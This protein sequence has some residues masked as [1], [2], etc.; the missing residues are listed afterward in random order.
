M[1]LNA[2]SGDIMI[3]ADKLKLLTS[4]PAS[5]LQQSVGIKDVTF[6]GAQFLGITNGGEFCYSVVYRAPS[7]EGTDSTK[8]FLKYDPTEDMVS[9]TSELTRW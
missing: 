2:I 4:F 6:T 9:A 5:A 8:V 1:Q 3:T 7:F